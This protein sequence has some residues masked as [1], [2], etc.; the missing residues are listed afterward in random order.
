M[1]EYLQRDGHIGG[2]VVEICSTATV[3][4][5]SWEVVKSASG[6]DGCCGSGV[7]KSVVV[8]LVNNE[9]AV[10]GDA[11]LACSVLNQMTEQNTTQRGRKDTRSILEERWLFC[12]QVQ[13][14]RKDTRSNVSRALLVLKC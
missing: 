8:V 4:V 13:R 2:L 10:G 1:L 14:G 3:L 7:G 5:A 11:M 12:N 6:R 9:V